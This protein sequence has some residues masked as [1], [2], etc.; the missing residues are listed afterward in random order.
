MLKIFSARPG[1]M[2][3]TVANLSRAGFRGIMMI[4]EIRLANLHAGELAR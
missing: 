2:I 4:S 1:K 3:I